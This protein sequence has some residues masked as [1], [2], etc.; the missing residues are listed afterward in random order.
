MVIFHWGNRVQGAHCAPCRRNGTGMMEYSSKLRPWL[1]YISW[2]TEE[3]MFLSR[4]GKLGWFKTWPRL[5]GN[6]DWGDHLP[7]RHEASMQ[8][9]RPPSFRMVCDAATQFLICMSII[10]N[11]SLR[12]C[13]M[14]FLFFK[15]LKGTLIL[16]FVVSYDIACQWS[17]NLYQRMFELD[18]DFFLFDNKRYV[19]FLVPKFH[20]LAHIA[21]C[22]NNFSFNFAKNVGRTDGESPERGW[23]KL[24]V[25]VPSTREM[26]PGSQRDILDCNIGDEN[27]KKFFGISKRNPRY[28]DFVHYW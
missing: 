25:L 24:N 1:I 22:Q 16:V 19:W 5:R 14:D 8:C 27:W 20:L 13:N 28:S 4:C 3:Y 10:V 23:V 18:H 12:Y 6:W 15:T 17:I 2:I 21:P 26:G 7:S 11:I 9:W